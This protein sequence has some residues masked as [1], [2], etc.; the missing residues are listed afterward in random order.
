MVTFQTIHDVIIS[1]IHAIDVAS[2]IPSWAH[3]MGGDEANLH[4]DVDI[5][6][7][8][9]IKLAYTWSS[10][11]GQAWF[12]QRLNI[13]RDVEGIQLEGTKLSFEFIMPIGASFYVSGEK[14]Y[15]ELSWA[16][17][18]AIP[19]VISEKLDAGKPLD[20]AI[21][22]NQGDG[23]GLLL[24][25]RLY[26]HAL[27]EL[28][29]R[30]LLVIAQY[31][32]AQYLA[33]DNTEEQQMIGNAVAILDQQ[34]L[35]ENRWDAWW[36]SA[37]AA[38]A[39]LECLN[40]K[41]KE[42]TIH[43]VAHSHIDMNWLWP[44]AETVEVCRRD[45]SSMLSLME[46]YPEFKFS[47]SQAA[48]YRD[49][50]SNYPEIFQGIKKRVDEGRWD[51][52]AS[53]WVENDLNTSG[54]EA[55]ARQFLYA[56]AYMSD[57]FGVKPKICWC[58]DTFGHPANIPQILTQAGVE[59]YYHCRAGN[60]EP[61]SRWEGIDGS[62]VLSTHDVNGYGGD[63]MPTTLVQ[64]MK[65]FATKL[66]APLAYWV[67]G[68][69]DH[70]GAATAVDIEHA[71][72]INAAPL[73]PTV[74]CSGSQEFFD[75]AKVLWADLPVHKG[76]MN[77]VFEGCYS[78]HA[79][80]KLM[81]RSSENSLI[82]AETISATSSAL[83]G[84]R[85]PFG[86]LAEA[87][88]ITCFHQFHDILCGC[89][90]GVTYD[91]AAVNHGM[92]SKIANRTSS[93]AA[94]SL[95]QAI[96][97]GVGQNQKLVVFNQLAWNRTDLVTIEASSLSFVPKAMK[98]SD[99]NLTPVQLSDG[100]LYF[101]ALNV[102]SM[103]CQVYT[104]MAEAE[105]ASNIAAHA[106]S[107]SMENEYL[108]LAVNP[109]SGALCNLV[110]KADGHELAGQGGGWGPEA[111]LTSG[112]L[113]RLQVLWEQP[114]PMSAWNIG[115]ITRVDHL[116]TGADVQ[117]EEVGPVFATIRINRSF[118]NSSLSQ[119]MRIYNGMPRVDYITSIDWHEQGTAKTDAPM[120]K[121]TFTPFIGSS[122]ATFET[123]FAPLV[124]PADGRECPALRWADVGDGEYGLSLMN[125]CKYG[126]S[127]HGNTLS[128]TLVRSSYEPDN[129]PD[130][131][132]HELIYSIYPYK[133]SWQ[134]AGS[135]RRAAELNQPMIT[136][137]TT[138]HQGKLKPSQPCLELDSAGVMVS[139]F[140]LAEHQPEEGSDYILRLYE[141]H[142]RATSCSLSLCIPCH[143]AFMSNILEAALSPLPL[144]D[145]KLSL[146][147]RPYEIVTLLFHSN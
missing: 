114:H 126:Y 14:R 119:K 47:Q 74:V 34:A 147:L 64:C 87:W 54:S 144:T 141:A 80:I 45:F 31:Q 113:N 56:N 53:E 128:L 124:R 29:F 17:S 127:A 3:Q 137:V 129:H 60:G 81:N 58:P 43:L 68:T 52:T 104:P 135:D 115:D 103:G 38:I 95:A 25:T 116:I 117:L 55:T 41:A 143:Q 108:K 12:R 24:H 65:H 51:V 145:G 72:V 39:S 8:E 120:L 22:A 78:S 121:T 16:D 44:Y 112:M 140:K 99:G 82:S 4:P 67:Y 71:R 1:K 132:M 76:E 91:E 9:Q 131:G 77:T 50:E 139:A 40:A 21:C 37:Q 75:K 138:A 136:T 33:G 36:Q 118:L 20:L 10:A 32:F 18:R 2:S 92:V 19:L 93:D 105:A 69:G 5:S 106:D 134:E 26:F 11:Q 133:G 23:F 28:R 35:T 86:D 109:A 15:S 83:L 102:P 97:T 110:L 73:M 130:E 107:L 7:W 85:Y 79:D 66:K 98:D 6:S 46:R 70:G 57:K 122:V 146:E 62:Q 101:V 94:G 84:T 96:D 88:R 13:P 100:K 30:L 90:I 63:V 142:G 48:T 49:M 123:P 59:Y 111:N 27:E 125:N 61:L 89:S 42:H